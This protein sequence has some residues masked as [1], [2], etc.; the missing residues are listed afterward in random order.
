MGFWSSIKRAK[1]LEAE[2]SELNK[3]FAEVSERNGELEAELEQER[4]ALTKT[5]AELQLGHRL[6]AGLGQFGSS[7]TELKGSFSDLSHLLGSRRSEAL[8]TR[9]ES[10]QVRDGMATLVQRLDGARERA[11]SSAGQM[12]ALEAETGSITS[13]VDVIDGVSDQT[14]LLALNASIEAARA[15]EH[16]R[17]FSVVATEVRNL[18]FRAGEATREIDEAINRIRSQTSAVSGASKSSSEEM[19]ALAEEAG[20]ARDRLMSLIGLA[21]NSSTALGNAALLAEI[22]LANLE[23]LE[24]KLTVYQILAG[25]SDRSADSLP[26]ETECRLGQWYYQGDGNEHY[27]GR[28]DFK[29]IEEPHRLV[30]VYAV[31]AVQAHQDNR[32]EDA[33]RALEAMEANNLDVMSRLR[34]L[35]SAESS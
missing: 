9:D 23:E 6:M 2:L 20:V 29:A 4:R 30:H 13:L 22:E 1:V 33:L 15:G 28:M 8:K 11:V 19:Q 18:A 16:G 12:E 7:L 3:A 14:S 21:D 5:R 24:I 34:K 27:A 31:E 32:P 25:L 26:A 17:G 10:G 35:V